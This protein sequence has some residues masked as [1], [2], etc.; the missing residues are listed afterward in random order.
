M[1][2]MICVRG[3][4]TDPKEKEIE[5]NLLYDY[6]WAIKA[7]LL[8]CVCVMQPI[9]DQISSETKQNV[10]PTI[11]HYLERGRSFFIFFKNRNNNGKKEKKRNKITVHI[12]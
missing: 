8:S 1:D 2:E 3:R 4:E 12:L 10:F 7:M 9:L 5:I 6:E 11:D